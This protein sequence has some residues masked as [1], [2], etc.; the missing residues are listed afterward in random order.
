MKYQDMPPNISLNIHGGSNPLALV[1]CAFIVTVL[2]AIV[3]V[4]SGILAYSSFAHRHKLSGLKTSIGFPLQAIGTVLLTLSLILCAG[5]INTGS[6]ERHWLREGESQMETLGKDQSSK[7]KPFNRRDM[8][9]YWIQKQHRASFNPYILY[10]EELD[11]EIHE[12]HRVDEIAR[13]T[14]TISRSNQIQHQQ[15][16]SFAG[17]PAEVETRNRTPNRPL[18]PL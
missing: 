9:L 10:A 13:T 6:C 3:L 17:F 2:Q 1:A 15:Y 11:D 18:L 4:W 14:E 12:S 8:Q 7:E 5:I 16:S